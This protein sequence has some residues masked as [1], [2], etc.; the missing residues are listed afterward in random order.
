M[1]VKDPKISIG[2]N[3]GLLLHLRAGEWIGILGPTEK[4]GSGCNGFDKMIG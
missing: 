3:N 1:F 2:V 4:R